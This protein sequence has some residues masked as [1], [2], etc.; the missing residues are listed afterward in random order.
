[1]TTPTVNDPYTRRAKLARLFTSGWTLFYGSILL[2]RGVTALTKPGTTP[3]DHRY[4]HLLVVAYVLFFLLVIAFRIRRRRTRSR[5]NVAASQVA[6]P[7]PSTPDWYAQ[8]W[9]DRHP[10]DPP[11]R[12]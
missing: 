11:T 3:T 9:P 2:S 4:A 12:R 6:A 1:M 10:A 7:P 5:V 8:T